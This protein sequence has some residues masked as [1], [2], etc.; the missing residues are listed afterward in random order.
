MGVISNLSD[1]L[2]GKTK[3]LEE[4]VSISE[5]QAIMKNIPEDTFVS[6]IPDIYGYEIHPLT[7]VRRI[8]EEIADFGKPFDGIENHPIKKIMHIVYQNRDG[9]KSYRFVKSYVI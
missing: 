7:T 4:E 2:Q 8:S 9:S 3:I 1:F 5:A 6:T